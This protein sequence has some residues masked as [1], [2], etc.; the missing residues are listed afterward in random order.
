MI[1]YNKQYKVVAILNSLCRLLGLFGPIMEAAE[2]H[3]PSLKESQSVR[4]TN[5]NEEQS[6]ALVEVITSDQAVDD[7]ST[8]QSKW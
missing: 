2:N 4:F 1:K 5:Q 7:E 6:E 8:A 3:P